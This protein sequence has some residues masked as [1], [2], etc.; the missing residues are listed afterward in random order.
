MADKTLNEIKRGEQAEK[1]LN[2]DVYKDAFN[3]VKNN[4]INAMNDSPLGDDKTH[5]RLVI[6]LQTLSQIEKALADVMQTGKM[7]KIQVEDKRFRVFG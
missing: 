7:A 3:V 6:A 1:I 2:N 4:I 5:N